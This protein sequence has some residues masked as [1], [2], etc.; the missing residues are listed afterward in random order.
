MVLRRIPRPQRPT[1]KPEGATQ[2]TDKELLLLCAEAFDAMP[3]A[4]KCR[5][6]LKAKLDKTPAVYAG[7]G[8][9]LL[10]AEMGRKIRAHLN[11]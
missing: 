2:M 10:S 5:K 3:V 7:N 8:G 4:A 1:H 9:Y 6:F 11:Q